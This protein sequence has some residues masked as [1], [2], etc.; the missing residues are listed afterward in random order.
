[1]YTLICFFIAIV[2]IEID[3][4][5]SFAPSIS[6]SF[7][8][9]RQKSQTVKILRSADALAALEQEE[10]QKDQFS[11]GSAISLIAGTTVGAGIIALPQYTLKIGFTFST[12]GLLATWSVMVAT[13]LLI[14]EI[15]S[16]FALNPV[17]NSE[18]DGESG[19]GDDMEGVGVVAI[20]GSVLGDDASK[21]TGALYLFLHYAILTAYMSEGGKEIGSIFHLPS[22]L[23]TLLYV[24]GAG[25]LVAKGSS[26]VQEKVNNSLVA[27]LVASFVS[28]LTIGIP[29]L[30]LS[31]LFSPKF[32]HPAA[33]FEAFPV[34]LLALV[35][36]NVVPFVSRK[37]DY[38][39]DK[40]SK[41]IVAGTAIPLT[42]FI[43]WNAVCLGSPG[44]TTGEIT[45]PAM[46]AIGGM[47][48][49][50]SLLVQVFSLFAINTSLLG[51]IYGILDYF[52]DIGFKIPDPD[53]QTVVTPEVDRR[54]EDG[55]Q[56]VAVATKSETLA[57]TVAQ[58]LTGSI[59]GEANPVWKGLLAN[60]LVALAL[61]LGPPLIVSEFDPDIFLNALD[62]A[63]L[64]GI[65]I[66]YGALPPAMAWLVRRKYADKGRS[67]REFVPG[68]TVSLVAVVLAIVTIVAER[69]VGG[70]GGDV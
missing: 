59:E 41:S 69:L 32:Q 16:N 31:T 53:A 33:V 12:L 42:M 70:S 25:A 13:G 45:D 23:A 65:S 6:K 3:I 39:P 30:S 38:D 5:M 48:P 67:Y 44:I 1:M 51:F 54:S 55:E 29:Q 40:I 21:V 62:V 14:A 4:V 58:G 27:V 2:A 17:I 61:A 36:H 10:V 68:G 52:L 24:T 11:V 8:V 26:A 57:N 7:C 9:V 56:P 49:I 47:G 37:L 50:A 35:Y 64:Y 18:R 63:G 34:F 19:G 60:P 43:L 15:S 20:S 22:Q 66:L 28:L 46:A